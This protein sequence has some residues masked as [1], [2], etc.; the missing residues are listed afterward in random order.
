[1][2]SYA[3]NGRHF[4][5]KLTTNAQMVGRSAL[6]Q[7][8]TINGRQVG[9]FTISWPLMHKWSAGWHFYN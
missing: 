6:M 4:Y 2:Q 3:I 7:S 1:M 8:Y 5:N 9:T